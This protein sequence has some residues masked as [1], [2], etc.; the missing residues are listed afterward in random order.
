MALDQLLEDIAAALRLERDDLTSVLLP[1]RQSIPTEERDERWL[2]VGEP[3]SVLVGLV[4]GVV[5]VAVP[6]FHWR[7]QVPVLRAAHQV[8]IT[9]DEHVLTNFATAV[10]DAVN[11][12]RR[13]FRRCASCGEDTPPEWLDDDSCQRCSE[14]SGTVH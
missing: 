14:A 5:I 9:V 13:S 6:K 7:S 11:T 4:D 12:R 10:R 8:Q 1:P 3:T 2:S